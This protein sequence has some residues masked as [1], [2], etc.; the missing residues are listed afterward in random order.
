MN[1]SR[2]AKQIEVE[3]RILH[4]TCSGKHLIQFLIEYNSRAFLRR[5]FKKLELSPPPFFF[6]CM[7]KLYLENKLSLVL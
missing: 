2:N 5:H 6:Q 1:F 3:K 7:G 4:A